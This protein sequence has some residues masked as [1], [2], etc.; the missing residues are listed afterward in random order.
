MR[1]KVIMPLRAGNPD[2]E[3]RLS[4]KDM[5]S[6][7][8]ASIREAVERPCRIEWWGEKG[9]GGRKSEADMYERSMHSRAW[10]S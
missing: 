2:G 5:W 7:D 6:A 4:I 3:T 8:D 9:S 10:A 1:L